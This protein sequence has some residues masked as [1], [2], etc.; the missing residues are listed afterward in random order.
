MKKTNI[1]PSSVYPAVCA[2]TPKASTSA[3]TSNDMFHEDQ[4]ENQ[5]EDQ[6]EEQDEEQY[7]G[8]DESSIR[9]SS[10]SSIPISSCKQTCNTNNFNSEEDEVDDVLSINDLP[11]HEKSD[12]EKN[13]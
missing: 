2:C 12:I 13:I 7:E 5:N 4:D 8:Q 3:S 6:D 1:I 10:S 9:R 11:E